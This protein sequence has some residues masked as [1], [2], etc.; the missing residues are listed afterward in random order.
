MVV[1]NEVPSTKWGVTCPTAGARVLVKAH[2]E[3]KVGVFACREGHV[4]VVEYSEMDPQEAASVDP[5]DPH[6]NLVC[7]GTSPSTLWHKA[8][9]HP[10][11]PSHALALTPACFGTAPAG[12]GTAPAWG[13]TAP[14]WFGTAPVWFCTAPVW[15]GT[16]SAW[17]WH[18]PCMLWHSPCMSLAQPLH[19]L[20]QPLHGLA[21]TLP[22]VDTD[23]A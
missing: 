7:L 17:L 5:G 23:A 15:F 3:E 12:F 4:E 11:P 16:A 21:Q 20:A 14:A 6:L 13:G 19:C 22:Y 1:S 18:S 10:L 9:P 8:S 2:P